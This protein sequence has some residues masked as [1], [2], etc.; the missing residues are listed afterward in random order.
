MSHRYPLADLIRRVGVTFGSVE[1]R[2]AAVLE[3]KSWESVFCVIRFRHE[4]VKETRQNWRHLEERFGLRRPSSALVENIPGFSM[5]S[6]SGV[7]SSAK[8]TQ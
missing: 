6:T 3:E 8:G 7:V 5:P 1:C 2:L 4:S